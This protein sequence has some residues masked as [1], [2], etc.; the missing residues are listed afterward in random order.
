MTNKIFYL[1][2]NSRRWVVTCLLFLFTSLQARSL[3]E[4]LSRFLFQ[5]S[6]TY[7]ADS[8]GVTLS[9]EYN[10]PVY[11][12][13]ED[14][15]ADSL[16]SIDV[17]SVQNFLDAAY[18]QEQW[19]VRL[20]VDHRYKIF[21]MENRVGSASD[22]FSTESNQLQARVDLWLNYG[23]PGNQVGLSLGRYF[24]GDSISFPHMSTFYEHPFTSF[25]DNPKSSYAFWWNLRRGIF[26]TELVFDKTV[27]LFEPMHL[28][29][30]S[31]SYKNL[32]LIQFQ[33]RIFTKV[34]LAS[35]KKSV[36]LWWERKSLT[37]E[38][39]ELSNCLPFLSEWTSY[40]AGV[41]ASYWE[42]AFKASALTSMGALYG[43]EDTKSNAPRYLIYD[44][45]FLKQ[46]KGDY[47]YTFPKRLSLGVNGELFKGNSPD[48]G[49]VE[50]YPF[51]S[52]SLFKPVKYRFSESL[53][54]YN[55]VGLTSKVS[56][57]R[58]HETILGLD[59]DFHKAE[60][61]FIREERKIVVLLPIYVDKTT[62][63]P[64]HHYLLSGDIELEQIFH[65]GTVDL[66][67]KASQLIPLYV[68]SFKDGEEGESDNKS[69]GF[70]TRFFGGFNASVALTLPF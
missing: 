15:L 24:P 17:Y 9:S 42:H 7:G 12:R 65:L 52:W 60:M 35:N 63:D 67:L 39:V 64:L 47:T 25:A 18:C 62:V 53:L 70:D 3:T 51:S 30:S 14:T 46:L 22:M 10:L 27:P 66:H 31:G 23:E 32:P 41:E 34:G 19:G 50:L 8:S 4:E 5:K 26:S 38:R 13:R 45:L 56:L 2:C 43:Y 29:K 16:L 44:D 55:K 36:S 69:T 33:R 61:S 1:I 58:K 40:K 68:K 6:Q 54:K 11:Y 37:G 21:G 49:T 28:S 59:M 57:G 20:H 48:K